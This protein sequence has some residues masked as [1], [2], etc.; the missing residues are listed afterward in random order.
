M[1]R[2][3]LFSLLS[4][5]KHNCVCLPHCLNVFSHTSGRP[6]V[7]NMSITAFLLPPE[8]VWLSRRGWEKP[9][10]DARAKAD[11]QYKSGVP[12]EP[13]EY[14]PIKSIQARD[15]HLYFQYEHRFIDYV[16][17]AFYNFDYYFFPLNIMLTST[18]TKIGR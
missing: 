2:L 18:T 14:L 7:G 6:C 8:S 3:P 4:Q 1:L 13:P 17:I 11:N 15:Y 12:L 5:S 10:N 9:Y 16:S